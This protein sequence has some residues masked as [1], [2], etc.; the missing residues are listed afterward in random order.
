VPDSQRSR[1]FA[2]G[3]FAALGSEE[4]S[5]RRLQ[6][7]LAVAATL[8]FVCCV[9]VIHL[10]FTAE[11]ALDRTL[12][13]VAEGRSVPDDVELD[14]LGMQ[15]QLQN[16]EDFR[17]VLRPRF[18]ISEGYTWPAVLARA[19]AFDVQVREDIGLI[20]DVLARGKWQISCVNLRCTRKPCVFIS[21]NNSPGGS[22]VPW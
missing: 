3:S 15:V 20:C 22:H 4:E 5:M 2:R 21:R 14:L 13:A 12:S 16:I 17:G 19:M 18:Q 10:R 8:A 11:G 6:R 7:I 1:T 9:Y